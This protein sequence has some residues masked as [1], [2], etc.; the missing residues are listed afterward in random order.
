[1]ESIGVVA[2]LKAMVE[3]LSEVDFEVPVRWLCDNKGA[4]SAHTNRLDI[5]TVD[6]G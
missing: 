5:L 4:G 3:Q 1:M 2:G 6:S